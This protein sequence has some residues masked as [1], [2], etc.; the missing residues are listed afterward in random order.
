MEELTNHEE[1][2]VLGVKL[3]NINDTLN[4]I[5][6]QTT[7]IEQRVDKLEQGRFAVRTIATILTVMLPFVVGIGVYTLNLHIESVVDI[8]VE[9]KLREGGYN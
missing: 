7:H 1:I 4:K 3:D 5:V 9:Q 8:R 6:T 2:A